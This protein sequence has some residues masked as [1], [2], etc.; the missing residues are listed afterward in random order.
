[1]AKKKTVEKDDQ[2]IS[3]DGNDYKF[4]EL[5]DEGKLVVNQLNIIESDI[6]KTKMLLDRHQAARQTFINQFKEIVV[7]NEENKKSH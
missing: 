7:D 3:L 2:I 6:L 5:S 4:S 1:M